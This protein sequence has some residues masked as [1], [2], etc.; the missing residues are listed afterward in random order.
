MIAKKQRKLTL[1]QNA[2][3]YYITPISTKEIHLL[4]TFL[5]V[6]YIFIIL[7]NCQKVKDCNVSPYSQLERFTRAGKPL[8]YYPL[9]CGNIHH[10]GK[11]YCKKSQE[12]VA[13][14]IVTCVNN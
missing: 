9:L 8:F 4:G 6:G 11:F 5:F 10:K 3:L 2:I 13:D 14:F 12:N 1:E 7:L